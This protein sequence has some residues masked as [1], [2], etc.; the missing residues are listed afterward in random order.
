MESN[1][2]SVAYSECSSCETEERNV[3]ISYISI[4]EETEINEMKEGNE[5]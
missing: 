2:K 1:Q 4:E 5:K 3:E